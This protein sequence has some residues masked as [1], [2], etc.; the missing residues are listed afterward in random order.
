MAHSWGTFEAISQEHVSHSKAEGARDSSRM[1]CPCLCTLYL[2]GRGYG[3]YGI[4][5]LGA[6]GFARQAPFVRL[7]FH[8]LTVRKTREREVCTAP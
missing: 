4:E 6:Q 2:R 3:I 7:L 1:L 8:G 5:G